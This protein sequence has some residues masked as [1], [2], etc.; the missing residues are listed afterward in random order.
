MGI[1]AE[2]ASELAEATNEAV[3]R[4]LA[5]EAFYQRG[6]RYFLQGH[7]E[8]VREIEG[9][10]EATVS[11]TRDYA[12]RLT[13][14]EGVLD[15]SCTCPVGGEGLFCKHCV[16]AALAW[17]SGLRGAAEGRTAGRAKRIRLSDVARLLEA[18]DKKALVD[19]VLGWARRDERLRKRLLMW[20]ARKSDA[21]TAIAEARRAFEAAVEVDDY[22]RY[23]EA[24]D[25]AR[26]VEEAVDLI[27]D[28][29]E[30][31]QAAAVV[32]LA[33]SC[34]WS[35]TETMGMV[36]DSDGHL[37]AI[38]YRLQHIHHRACV[39][40]RPNPEQLAR[41]LFH[42]ELKGRYDVFSG[43]VIRYAE[44][45]G[46]KGLKV[47][48]TLAEAEWERTPPRQAGDDHMWWGRRY[49]ITRIME[50]LA[51][52]SGDVE[53]L[54]EVMSRDLSHPSCYVRIAETYRKSGDLDKALQW[55]EKGLKAFGAAGDSTLR[56]FVAEEY[57]RRGRH[58]EAMK[59]VWDAFRRWHTPDGFRN[60]K[61]H[62][63]KAGALKEWRERGL[64]EIQNWVAK[65]KRGGRAARR[66]GWFG[67]EID[68][69]V[70]VA[71]FLDEGDAEAAWR[72]AQEGGCSEELWLRLAEVREKEHPEE[73][74]PIYM[75]CAEAALA[76]VRNS[77]YEEPVRLL[78]KAAAAMKRAGRGPKFVRYL[79]ELRRQHRRRRNFI[80]LIDQERE[81]L[82]VG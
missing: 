55:A 79:D 23:G 27:E 48:Q 63:A 60:L 6:L 65:V 22:L 16:A 13:A 76:R 77:R 41:R 42:W 24:A 70:L 68:H 29:L 12:V 59:L 51:K 14:E 7:V 72:E 74:A 20:A 2:M 66:A 9:G 78:K 61:R 45:L 33:E 5:G 67:G 26:G 15:Y 17:L 36:D 71:I 32:E 10:L 69:S 39:K 52:L 25:Y 31:G 30:A 53:R 1:M 28:L 19:M 54:V 38:C 3:V 50:S 62:A 49:A 56:E 47:Y 82:D 8:S 37:G 11:G 21:E 80:K 40:A 18:E 44:I 46:E 34:L 43:A 64:E 73:A 4:R 81:A 57:H 58:D 35:L 75:R